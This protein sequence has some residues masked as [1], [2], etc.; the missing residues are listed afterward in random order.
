MLS[1]RFWHAFSVFKR[2]LRKKVGFVRSKQLGLT[3]GSLKVI[4]KRIPGTVMG[5][6]FR[7]HK[8]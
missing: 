1:P 3:V 2:H 6:A 8:P 7:Y 5:D 4:A